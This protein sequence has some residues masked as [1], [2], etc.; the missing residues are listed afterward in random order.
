[1]FSVKRLFKVWVVFAFTLGTAGDVHAQGFLI[2]DTNRARTGM[3][4]DFAGQNLYIS[5]ATG[6]I[7]TFNLSTHTFGRSYNLGGWV[8]GIDIARDDSFILAAQASVSG[9]QGTFQRVNLATGAITNIHY[10]R[11]SSEIGGWDV[12]IGSNGLAMV[13]TQFAG[14]GWTPLRQIDLTTN[15][16]TIRTDAPGSG[17]GGQVRGGAEEGTKIH[18][19]A[20][21]TRFLFMEPDS[22]AGPFFTYSALTNTFGPSFDNNSFLDNSAGAVSPNGNL[23]ALSTYSAFG[24][25]A[26]LNTAPDLGLVHAFNQ[27]HSGIAFDAVRDIL[28]GVNTITEQI[29]AYSTITFA[30]LFRLPIGEAIG[31]PPFTPFDTGT[32]VA[33][34]DGR[35]LALETGSGI[36]IFHLPAPAFATNP[37][38]NVASFSA[39]LNGSLNPHGL[40]TNAYFQYGPTTSYG[41]TT[42]IKNQTGNTFRSLSANINGL[43]TNTTYHFRIVATNSAGTRYGSDRTF[44]TLSPTG[45]PVVTTH[46][47][48]N[49]SS[50]SVSL[51]SATLAGA[52]DPHGLTTTVYFQYGST[53]NYGFTTPVQTQTGSTFRNINTHISGLMNGTS[54]HFRIVATNS[55]GTRYG[56]DSTFATTFNVTPPPIV[57]TNPARWVASFSA[58]L[59]GLLNPCILNTNLYFQY[60]PTTNYGFNTPLQ[61]L[62]GN[63]FHNVSA[64]ISGLSASTTYHYRIV[65]TNLSG[66]THTS[67]ATFTTLS[68]TGLPIVVTT[69]ASGLT[70]SGATLHG[71]LDPHGLTTTVYFQYGRTNSYGSTTPSQTQN[72]NT[73]R[74]IGANISGLSAG[75]PYHFRIVATNSVGTRYGSDRT[76][77]TP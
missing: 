56:A 75:T 9:S 73:F 62:T 57:T 70:G 35:W 46:P 59:N 24:W 10:T 61:T 30:E 48:L 12:A 8:W 41:F 36:R 64:N 49:V 33:S 69:P 34:P 74:N 29:I 66:S 67:D 44:A 25:P 17:A 47:A 39:V 18:R 23:I 68:A 72:G 45:P 7:K 37:A 53:T 54:Y 16:I 60:G 3:V 28:Y 20:D 63:T 31:P 19:S 58:T 5:T 50:Y 13:T 71:S 55:A 65:A 2:S 51:A 6:L 1:M 15:A 52:L 77:T 26:W 38:T 43:G 21:G 11:A 40:T 27:I 14:S 22:S 32:L 42:P 4:F 76:F